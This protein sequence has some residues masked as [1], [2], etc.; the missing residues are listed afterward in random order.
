MSEW[1]SELALVSVL[2]VALGVGVG[3]GLGL[4]TA[5]FPAPNQVAATHPIILVVVFWSAVGFVVDAVGYITKRRL[6]QIVTH[7][8]EKSGSPVIK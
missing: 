1:G 3:A 2:G 7:R 6:K 8:F 5:P 4:E